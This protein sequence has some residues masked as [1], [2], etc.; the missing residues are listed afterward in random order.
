MK[1]LKRGLRARFALRHDSGCASLDS[2]RGRVIEHIWGDLECLRFLEGGS[3]WRHLV[4]CFMCLLTP[5]LPAGLALQNLGT[6]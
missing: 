5:A 6:A 4:A 3:S 2:W 1:R